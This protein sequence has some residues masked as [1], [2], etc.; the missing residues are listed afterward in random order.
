ML[1]E[2]KFLE[3]LCAMACGLMVRSKLREGLRAS[4]LRTYSFHIIFLTMHSSQ[5]LEI[6]I[7]FETVS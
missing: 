4:A 3:T 6:L 2:R 7:A 5:L 1:T